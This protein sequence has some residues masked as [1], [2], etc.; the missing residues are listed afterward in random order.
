[1]NIA[2]APS[3]VGVR[4]TRSVAVDVTSA[5]GGMGGVVEQQPTLEVDHL[6]AIHL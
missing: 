2:A 6:A 5:M 3:V 4:L 1:M